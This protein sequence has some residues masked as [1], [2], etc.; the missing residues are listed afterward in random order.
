M[1]GEV[2]LGGQ[3]VETEANY[4]QF[5]FQ[6]RERRR[7]VRRRFYFTQ[8]Q[9]TALA[10]MFVASGLVIF[11]LGTTVGKKIHKRVISMAG[12]PAVHASASTPN[13]AVQL[14]AAKEAG[15]QTILEPAKT[16]PT[17]HSAASANMSKKWSVQVSATPAKD[18]ADTLVQRLKASG[19]DGYVVQ[20]EVKGQTYYRLRVGRFEARE[21]AESVRQSLARQVG[22]RDAYLT[23]D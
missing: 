23:G 21:E 20:A 7:T 22:Y 13:G 1:V 6:E 15:V 19:Y 11:Y 9:G 16:N 3:K 17:A 5:P 12:K 8:T 14:A 18:I 4:L 10:A 2:G